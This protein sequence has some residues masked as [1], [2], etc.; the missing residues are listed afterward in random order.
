M[1]LLA[2]PSLETRKMPD[3]NKSKLETSLA[4][5]NNVLSVRTDAASG[6]RIA[7]RE[8]VCAYFLAE[9]ARGTPL[10]DFTRTLRQ[11]LRKAGD[12]GPR[13]ADAL[14]LQL[15]DWCINFHL[16]RERPL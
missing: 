4:E 14:A 16:L 8:A 9:R 12:G 10:I 7:L 13:V 5:L 11:L 2:T 15:V 1:A 6:D 3:N